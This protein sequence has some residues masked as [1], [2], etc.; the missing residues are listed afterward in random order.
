MCMHVGSVTSVS[1]SSQLP[2]NG[3]L[4]T[5][6]LYFLIATEANDRVFGQKSW[7]WMPEGPK[8]RQKRHLLQKCYDTVPELLE[9]RE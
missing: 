8:S 1:D 7:F 5:T 4:Q 3:C 9:F 6:G 2:Y